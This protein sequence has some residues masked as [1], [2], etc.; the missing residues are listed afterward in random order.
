[1]TF[2][3]L[4]SFKVVANNTKLFIFLT[5]TFSHALHIMYLVHAIREL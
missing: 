2:Y 1:M 5:K 3:A 4:H